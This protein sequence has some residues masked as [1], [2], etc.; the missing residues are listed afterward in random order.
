MDKEYLKEAWRHTKKEYD[1]LISTTGVS[2][3]TH[4]PELSNLGDAEFKANWIREMEYEFG[5][6]Y[7]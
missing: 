1:I 2:W 3:T 6:W 4:Y 7:N 5:N